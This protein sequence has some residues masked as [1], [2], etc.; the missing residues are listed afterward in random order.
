M[1]RRERKRERETVRGGVGG[2]AEHDDDD[3]DDDRNDDDD[4]GH[5]DHQTLRGIECSVS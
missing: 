1:P 3:N 4:R 5:Q 2:Y